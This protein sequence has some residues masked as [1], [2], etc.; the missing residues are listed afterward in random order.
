M[1]AGSF[2]PKGWTFCQGQL[3]SIAKYNALFSI[4]GATYGGD[5]RTTF[6]LPNLGGRVPIGTGKSTGTSQY[7]NGQ[8][9][10]AETVTLSKAE[11]PQHNHQI[12]SNSG[13]GTVS[14]PKGKVPATVQFQMD[15]T[16]AVYSINAY[17]DNS[18]GD[19]MNSQTILPAGGNNPYNNMQPFLGMNFITICL[20]GIYPPRD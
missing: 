3:L 4:L 20:E 19:N 9:G 7:Q 2:A 13:I 18:S 1:F 8:A 12:L 15:S 16:S 5:G 17:A 14:N 11:M 10:G 6:T